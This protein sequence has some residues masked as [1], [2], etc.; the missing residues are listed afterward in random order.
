M[1]RDEIP[2]ER[3]CSCGALGCPESRA[4]SG[5]RE[6]FDQSPG[7]AGGVPVRSISGLCHAR[8][9][10]G[11]VINKQNA[12]AAE[13]AAAREEWLAGSDGSA[14]EHRARVAVG[15]AGK[16]VARRCRQARIKATKPS[17]AER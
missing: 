11:R 2:E 8:I 15:R 7:L 13:D 10:A 4:S 14:L 6:P 1:G 5:R 9:P 16:M 3:L 17:Q 12:A